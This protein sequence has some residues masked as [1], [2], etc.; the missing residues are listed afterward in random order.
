[1]NWSLSFDGLFLWVLGLLWWA[2]CLIFGRCRKSGSAENAEN[3]RERRE[4]TA[5]IKATIL[6]KVLIKNDLG[7][8][9]PESAENYFNRTQSGLPLIT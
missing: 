6:S 2:G 1:L 9:T 8:Y 7:S 4:E 5:R 3:R